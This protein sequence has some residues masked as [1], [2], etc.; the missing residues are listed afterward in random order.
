MHLIG[1]FLQVRMV[2]DKATRPN[3]DAAISSL[4]QIKALPN[5]YQP[6]PK[7]TPFGERSKTTLN[8]R[9]RKAEPCRDAEQQKEYCDH[10]GILLGVE[11]TSAIVSDIN[12]VQELECTD[13]NAFE[14][15]QNDIVNFNG[16]REERVIKESATN[17]FRSIY[18]KAI[19]G[20]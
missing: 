5:K 4:F 16:M 9:K 7:P 20:K 10:S 2:T 14:D 12:V 8:K 13:S 11:D 3:D 15:M 1:S 19:N 6:P 18:S 17:A